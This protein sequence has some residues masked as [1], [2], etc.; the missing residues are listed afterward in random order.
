[1]QFDTRLGAYVVLTDA[2]RI[3][4]A[5]WTAPFGP[6][7]TAVGGGVELNETCEEA[8]VREAFEETGYQIELGPILG[9]ST[10]DVPPERRLRPDGQKWLKVVRVVYRGDIVGGELRPEVGGSTDQCRWFTRAEIAELERLDV[11][12]VIL[13]WLDAAA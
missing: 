12:D 5:R 8:A 13:G 1:M 2:D 11:V 10:Y 3:L 9:V 4:L 7:W 6:R